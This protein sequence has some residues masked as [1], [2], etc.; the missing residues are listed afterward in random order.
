MLGLAPVLL[1]A[2]P[3]WGRLAQLPGGGGGGM[4][5]LFGWSFRLI[6]CLDLEPDGAKLDRP[7][8]AL[9]K[10]IW[11]L[12]PPSTAA[13]SKYWRQSDS[14]APS[15]SEG[16]TACLESD[17]PGGGCRAGLAGGNAPVKERHDGHRLDLQRIAEGSGRTRRLPSCR[18]LAAHACSM[19]KSSCAAGAATHAMFFPFEHARNGHRPVCPSPVGVTARTQPGSRGDDLWPKIES[20]HLSALGPRPS[21]SAVETLAAFSRTGS[22]I[23]CC[24]VMVW[25]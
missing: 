3:A 5:R 1:L 6:A 17:R 8:M 20:T 7:T 11:A 12:G 21:R 4:R 23:K 10:S 25:L 2:S 13:K 14:P 22:E 19:T 9:E 24:D 18:S 16:Q 15:S